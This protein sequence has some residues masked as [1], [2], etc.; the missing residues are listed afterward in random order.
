LFKL[1]LAKSVDWGMD[2]AER[3]D[4]QAATARQGLEQLGGVLGMNISKD[5]LE[6]L[7]SEWSFCIAPGGGLIPAIALQ[8]SLD[9]RAAFEKAHERLLGMAVAAAGE[10]GI[11]IRK[12]DYNGQT[13]HCLKAGGAAP[14]PVT[15]S[16]CLAKDRLIVTA[17]PQLMKTLLSRGPNDEGLDA[18]PEV[19]R[20][21]AAGGEAMVGYLEPSALMGTLFSLYEMGAPLVEAGLAQQQI[22]MRMPELPAASAVM[23]NVRPS[24]T[25]IRQ[26]PGADGGILFDSTSTVPLGPLSSGGGLVGGAPMS[27]PILVGLLLPA[28][29]SAREAARRTQAMNNVRQIVLSLLIHENA[30]G[31]LP[32]PAICDKQG[33]PLLSWRVAMLPYLEEQ[34]LYEQFRLDE[35]WDSEHNKKLVPLMPQVFQDPGLTE[36][37]AAGLTT[38]QLRRGEKTAFP[39]DVEGLKLGDISDGTSKTLAVVE[40]SAER[41][42]PW[43]KPEDLAFD[44]DKPFDGLGIDR[45]PGGLFIAAFL[46]GHVETLS[47]DVPPEV[48][49]AIV[50]PA[51]GDV[52]GE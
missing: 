31:R 37:G 43:T 35:P 22:A 41:A 44:P 23:P 12:V 24:V 13:I 29:Q 25:V 1:D 7:G 33:K 26:V 34:A 4:P 15:P 46:D 28:V 30:Q 14:L 48:I 51:A 17:S 20:A 11:A 45:R 39:K 5:V 40:V 18:V 36:Q 49:K 38:F 9:D 8:V 27:A 19:K 2:F 6:P 42:V 32:A 10:G 47:P 52:V 21:M 3:L 16:W 50:T